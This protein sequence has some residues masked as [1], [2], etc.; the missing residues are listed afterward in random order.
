MLQTQDLT[1]IQLELLKLF[2]T[3]ISDEETADIKRLIVQ[4]YKAK[5]D[6]EMDILW[7]ERGYTDDTATQWLEEHMR[8]PYN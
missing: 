5:L 2:S 4:Y 3:N 7:E 1:N 8:T 6:R